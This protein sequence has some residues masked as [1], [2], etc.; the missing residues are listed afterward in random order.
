M[1]ALC[2][3]YWALHFSV[4]A[5]GLPSQTLPATLEQSLTGDI[6]VLFPRQPAPQAPAAAPA[7]SRFQILGVMAAKLSDSRENLALIAVDGKPA[8]PYRVG[9]VVDGAMVLQSVTQHS[10]SLG[11]QSG[12][13]A[14]TL[15]LP[16]LPPPATGQFPASPLQYSPA[17]STSR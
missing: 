9:N 15:T 8:H 4:H 5:E 16:T 1:V 13:T 17:T 7:S 3:V 12:P 10:A 14:F 6:A 2:A 11:P